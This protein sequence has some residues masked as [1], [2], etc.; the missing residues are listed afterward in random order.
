M[1]FGL[2]VYISIL[3]Q[4]F[5]LAHSCRHAPC[6]SNEK[7]V[8]LGMCSDLYNFYRTNGNLHNVIKTLNRKSCGIDRGHTSLDKNIEVCCP[9]TRNHHPIYPAECSDCKWD[10]KCVTQDECHSIHNIHESLKQ[11][12]IYWPNNRNF[13]FVCCPQPGDKLPNREF[14]GQ[15]KANLRIL[16]GIDTEPNEF[17]WMT[18]LMYQNSTNL[19]HLCGGSLINNRYVLTAAHCVDKNDL[20]FNFLLRSVRLGEHNTSTNPDCIIQPNG[21]IICA[22][23]HL[24][25]DVENIFVHPTYRGWRNGNDI[26]LLRL[27]VPVRYTLQIQPICVPPN[28]FNLKNLNLT[29]AGWGHTNNEKDQQVKC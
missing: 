27:E 26:A 10:E 9:K 8:S 29:I 22:P 3:L 14:C 12:E 4:S 20:P 23:L 19:V 25:V 6:K 28:F 24:E 5:L 18:L 13:G 17:P 15:R 2:K 21:K 1:F 7:C 16:N 11:N